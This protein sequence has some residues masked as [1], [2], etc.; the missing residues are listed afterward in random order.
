[1]GY[2][3]EIDRF[4]VKLN[5][6]TDDTNYTVEEELTF[7]DGKF[8]GLL[9]HDNIANTTIRVY[10][11]SKLTGDVVTNYIISVPSDT[12]WRRH[13]K[14]FADVDKVYATYETQGDTVE[15]DDVNVLQGAITA[16][17]EE[18]DRYKAANDALVTNI[19]ARL[20]VAEAN[21]AEKTYVDTQLLLKADKA[22]TF[23]LNSLTASGFYTSFGTHSWSMAFRY[24][25]IGY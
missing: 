2:P 6:K 19:N 24:I 3:T 21:K 10:T 22:N 8:E 5:K 12:P 11:G 16:T 18:V 13:I 17:E 20:T 14:V 25:A 7:T 23:I 1:M 9:A 4:P 15:A